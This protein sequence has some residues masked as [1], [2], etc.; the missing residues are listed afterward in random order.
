MQKYVKRIV[1]VLRGDG[2]D[3]CEYNECKYY[4]SGC[5]FIRLVNDAANLI[6]NLSEEL[7]QV[8]KERD[9]AVSDARLGGHCKKCKYIESIPENEPCRSCCY[10]YGDKDKWEWRGICKENR[11]I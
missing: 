9:A 2:C 4:G 8:K 5:D 6:E 7:E 1:R 3:E 11:K 10:A